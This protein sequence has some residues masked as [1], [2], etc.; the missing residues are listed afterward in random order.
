MD[1][2][3][4]G[5]AVTRLIAD[6]GDQARASSNSSPHVPE[7]TISLTL[8]GIRTLDQQLRRPVVSQ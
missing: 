8:L 7:H 4:T 2:P 1:E 5:D 3:F 6:A